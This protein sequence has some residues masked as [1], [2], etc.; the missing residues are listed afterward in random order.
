MLHNRFFFF[1]FLDNSHVQEVKLDCV[2]GL[3]A[4]IPTLK[5][6]GR[7]RCKFAFINN[8]HICHEKLMYFS[9]SVPILLYDLCN[10]LKG[11]QLFPYSD[12]SRC[13]YNGLVYD[14]KI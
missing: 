4:F 5:Y 2:C 6:L 12:K 10:T 13:V 7:A 3:T 14:D 1:F 11:T 9:T 8:Y